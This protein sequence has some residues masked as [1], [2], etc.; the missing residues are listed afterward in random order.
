MSNE[1]RNS[2][3]R[4]C[5]IDIRNPVHHWCPMLAPYGPENHSF[6]SKWFFGVKFVG[7]VYLQASEEFKATLESKM[8]DVR[9]GEF[10]NAR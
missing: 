10:M 1:T 2:D 3:P 7:V 9:K 6:N 4:K 5:I 8:D